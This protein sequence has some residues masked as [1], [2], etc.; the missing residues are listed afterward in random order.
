[1][2][3]IIQDIFNIVN[4]FGQFIIEFCRIIYNQ[5]IPLVNI[6]Q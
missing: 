3:F 5:I 4:I 1:M 2:F 6:I